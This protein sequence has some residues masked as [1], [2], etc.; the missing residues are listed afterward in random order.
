MDEG[1][2]I[3]VLVV[4][5]I[6]GRAPGVA[7]SKEEFILELDCATAGTIRAAALRQVLDGRLLSGS[8]VVLP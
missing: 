2:G 1:T 3:E 7:V 5:D 4:R 6:L 8:V